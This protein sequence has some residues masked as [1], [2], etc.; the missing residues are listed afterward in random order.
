METCGS[1]SAE[2]AGRPGDG[3]HHLFPLLGIQRVPF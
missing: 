2:A 1:L 3:G